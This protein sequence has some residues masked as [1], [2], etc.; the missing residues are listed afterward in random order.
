MYA[1]KVHCTCTS[2]IHSI[3]VGLHVHVCNIYIIYMAHYKCTFS[4]YGDAVDVKK[5]EKRMF[6]NW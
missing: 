1:M 5:K 6:L 3:H 2:N 4:N